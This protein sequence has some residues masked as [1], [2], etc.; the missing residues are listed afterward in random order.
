ML[1][2]RNGG[3]GGGGFITIFGNHHQFIKI[4]VDL[5]SS[6]DWHHQFIK[7][8]FLFY[9]LIH[10]LKFPLPVVLPLYTQ[11]Q[12]SDNFPIFSASSACSFSY[13]YRIKHS[14]FFHL[15]APNITSNYFIPTDLSHAQ[16]Q[17]QPTKTMS[18]INTFEVS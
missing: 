1:M 5:F 3:W 18:F 10:K 9:E 13:I 14:C 4:L 17:N 6:D 12:S 11:H 15:S 16:Q 8:V 2:L 7:A